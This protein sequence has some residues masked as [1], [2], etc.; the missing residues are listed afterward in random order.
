MSYTSA[1]WRR[2][3]F[4]TLLLAIPQSA[5]IAIEPCRIEVIDKASGWPVPL[6]ELRTVNHVR[7]IT[8]NAGV[9]AFDLPEAMGRET[10]LSVSGHGYTVKADV[11]G[12]RGVRIT[13]QP[14]KTVKIEVD[15]TIIAKRIG[16]LTGSGLFGESAKLD[17]A[18][19]L[20]ESGILGCDSVQNAVFNG[21]LYWYW[22]DT[23]LPHY[24]L[25]IF[26]APGATTAVQP[27]ASLEPPLRLRF[28]YFRDAEGKPRGVA[29]MPGDGPTWVTGV[30]SLP[31]RDGVAH[32]LT[33]YMKVKSGLDVYLWGLAEW[34]AEREEFAP[35]ATIWTKSDS[36]P[37][38]PPIPQGHPVIWTD[39]D[40]KRW[41]VFGDPFPSL[42]CPA[43]Y[44]AWKD[45][46]QW[47]VLTPQET[48]VDHATGA[49]IKPHRGSICW[50]DFRKR[51]VTVFTQQRGKPSA[52]GEQWYAEADSPFGPWGH[53]VK[54][55]S[56][57]NYTFYNPRLHPE[58][59][60]DNPRVLFFEGT[61]TTTFANRPEETPR[62][63]YN[64]IL[65][66]L[67]LDDAA[68]AGA[69]TP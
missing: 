3:A 32:L 11:F 54:V 12:Y 60:A 21:K 34:N 65:Y 68:L 61:Y 19:K 9:I 55:L 28:N 25:G 41:A 62:Y 69:Q 18:L 58:F 36:A 66:R 46:A 59:S 22:G 15:R 8:D 44:E 40:G 57:D 27:L 23:N 56:H 20:D 64:Q 29:K 4:V 45:P 50:N 37:K 33:S 26:D 63:D 67:D 43:T 17:P 6:V 24:P 35:L 2:R 52:L 13:P 38:P 42:K 30:I 53:T 51:W 39:S 49:A 10:W 7:F 14:A 1:S 31:D 48:L 16:R 5:L 47:S